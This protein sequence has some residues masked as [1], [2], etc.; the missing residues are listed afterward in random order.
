MIH[1]GERVRYLST[2]PTDSHA[3]YVI[4]G[5]LPAIYQLYP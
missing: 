5:G 2:R 4:R 3:T 1:D